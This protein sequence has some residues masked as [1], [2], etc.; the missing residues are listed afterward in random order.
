MTGIKRI[1]VVMIIVLGIVLFFAYRYKN[2]TSQETTTM[3][4]VRPVYGH[5]MVTLS[6]TGEVEPQNRLQI[7]PSISGRIDDILVK[8]GDRV[9][10]G[11]V[12][13]K[14][15][16]TERAAL[17]DVARAQG[18]QATEYWENVYKESM[19]VSPIDGEVIVR[20]VEP[21]QTVTTADTVLVLS[22][23]LIMKAQFDET[24]IARVKVGQKAFITLD[25]YPQVKIEG[26]VDHI[27]YESQIVNNVIIYDVDIVPVEIPE[28]LRSGMSANVTVIEKE[29]DNVLMI[30]VMALQTRDG[31]K[32]VFIEDSSDKTIETR[33]VETGLSD[34]T[35]VEIVSGLHVND[36]VVIQ[37][38]MYIPQKENGGIN[39]FMPRRR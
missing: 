29:K 30:P 6:T 39:P 3:R 7:K 24:D 10:R 21:G 2:G 27:A 17:I 37:S 16:S 34:D 12:L 1:I 38:Q 22:D 23:R 35:N 8:E 36:T 5:I 19:L 11:E 20:D 26:I 14:M 32:V 15:S 13:A 4:M 33:P 18:D 9:K 28:F 31:R 25:A